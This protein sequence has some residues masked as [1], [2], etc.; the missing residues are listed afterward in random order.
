MAKSNLSLKLKPQAVNAWTSANLLLPPDQDFT[1]NDFA[2]LYECDLN[3]VA[4]PLKQMSVDDSV[5]NFTFGSSNGNGDESNFGPDINA[6]GKICYK[7]ERICP[8]CLCNL[9][10]LLR[11]H[12]VWSSHIQ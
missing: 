4:K 7:Q 8:S 12:S 2:K 1:G 10:I 11:D 5:A 6:A 3:V 9:E